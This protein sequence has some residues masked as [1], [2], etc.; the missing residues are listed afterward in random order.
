MG[1]R[2]FPLICLTLLLGCSKSD[3][4]MTARDLVAE[5]EPVSGNSAPDAKFGF[6]E[7]LE[8][9]PDLF[10]QAAPSAKL[11]AANV[12][13]DAL[14]DAEQSIGEKNSA[15]QHQIA[16]SYGFGFRV[17]K[18]KIAELQRA[19]TAQC[20][21][22]G[23]KCRILRISEATGDWDGYGEIKLEVA[24]SEAGDFGKALSEPAIRLGGELVS[25]VRDGEDLSDSII[26]SRLL[27]RDKLTAILRNNKGSVDELIKAEQ[28]V[29]DVNE[30]IDATRSK[31]ERYRDRIQYSDVS[32]EYQPEFG[33]SQ[34]G[35][36]R[37]VM[38]AVRSIGT[39][40]G[41]TIAVLIYLMTALVPITL[42]VLA[43]RW[44]LHRFGVR[45]RF[46][47]NK[48]RHSGG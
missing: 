43:L 47:R 44:V 37:P 7:A 14:H 32:I 24:A 31:L 4:G 38:T 11:R 30:Q 48:P 17:S 40:L 13:N 42:L 6:A 41:T 34:L 10:G 26:S 1:L 35:F 28:A 33:Q 27:L 3:N 23:E 9:G 15:Q 46:W 2:Y 39:T 25:S 5:V 29:A 21:A 18:N 19:H 16:Y 36:G 8:T 45:L 12:L 20:N 22:M